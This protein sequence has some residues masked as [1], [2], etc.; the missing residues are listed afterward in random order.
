MSNRPTILFCAK[1]RVNFAMFEPVYRLLAKDDDIRIRASSGHYRKVPLLGWMNPR[2]AEKSNEA[3]LGE[4]GIDPAHLIR[5]SHKD[6][7]PY[8]LYVASNL[9]PRIQPRN[10]SFKVQIFHGVSFRNFAVNPEYLRFDKL[11][12]PGRYMMEQYVARGIL[13]EGDPKGEP[14]GM[15]KLDRL[16]N[17]ELT[18]DRELEKLGLDPARPTVAWCP[19]GARHNG[20]EVWGA[21]GIRA[22]ENAGVNLIVK[23]HDHPHLAP[24]VTRES[25]LK[26]ARE[27]MG[28]N[29]RLA[30]RSD[31][32]PVL[33]AADLLLSDASSVAFEYCLLDRPILFLD[34]PKLL[35]RRG[36]MEGSAMDLGTHGR[37]VGRIVETASG[38][39][40]A[41]EEELAAPGRLSAERRAA[42]SH[43][44]HEPGTAAPRM[45]ARLKALALGK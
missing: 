27:A 45:A 24:G 22:I 35:R 18:R 44:F 5:T 17:G 40:Q 25:V 1:H 38:L 3:I 28:P 36:E 21:E 13:K 6:P 2:D 8:E 26:A 31:V 20:F 9:S 37:N 33:A 30:D 14:M 10:V 32:A 11:F 34:V 29:S 16:V 4:F 19:T 12:F 23:L 43:I 15:P 7:H 39:T 41:I 42:A